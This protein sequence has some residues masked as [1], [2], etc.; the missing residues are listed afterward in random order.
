VIF[1]AAIAFAVLL[2]TA[3][4]IAMLARDPRFTVAVTVYALILAAATV[5]SA[6]SSLAQGSWSLP[7]LMNGDGTQYFEQAHALSQQGIQNYRILINSNYVGYQLLLAVA[8]TVFGP[9][10]YVGI[11][12]NCI[13]LLLTVATLA[14]ATVVLTGSREAGLYASVAFMLTTVSIFY[15]MVLLKEPALFLSFGL[16]LLGLSYLLSDQPK[17]FRALVY[18]AVA[19]AIIV[20]MRSSLLIFIP[21]LLAF[22]IDQVIKRRGYLVL[23]AVAASIALIPFAQNFT[24]A[25]LDAAFF[26]ETITS[27]EV[28][29]ARFQEGFIDLTGITGIFS[30]YYLPLPFAA[31]VALF[32]FPLAT[33]VYLPFNF[34]S[35]EF[36]SDHPAAFFTQ[37][38]NI[39]WFAFVF[40]WV[41]FSAIQFR[42][43]PHPTVKRFFAA[44]LFYYIVIAIVYAGL[45]PRYGIPALIFM[46]PSV[47]YWWSTSHHDHTLRLR[48]R[49]TFTLYYATFAVLIVLYIGFQ[50]VR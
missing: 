39:L 49:E 23:G 22:F 16:I 15:A 40:V 1:E 7:Y 25:S 28:I 27:N 29:S 36:I 43:C 38:M 10:L 32:P 45:I 50:A 33:Q 35:G 11:V 2:G 24:N 20:T 18:L 12:A 48:V 9:S 6:E 37:N 21:I 41:L 14:R 44:G 34:W 42:N 31:K 30:S 13:L 26:T 47:G 4:I 8:F 19:L 3:G 46:F 17:N 5:V